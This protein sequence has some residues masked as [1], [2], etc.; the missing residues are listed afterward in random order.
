MRAQERET[1]SKSMIGMLAV[2]LAAGTA[3]AGDD[4]AMKKLSAKDWTVPGI[5]M[6]TKFIP[7]GT[8]TMGSPKDEMCRRQD[9]VQHRVAISKPFYMGVYEVTQRQFYKLMMPPDYDYEAWQ[10]KRGPIH[11]GAAFC[12][13]YRRT[14]P[15]MAGGSAVGGK[16]TD[17]NPMECVTWERAR[18]F[19]RKLTEIE[20][21]AGRLPDGY[22]YRLPTEAEWE[23]ACRAGTQG[24]YNVEGEYTSLSSIRKFAW[25]DTFSW[26]VFGTQEVG[27][28]RTPNAW[29]LYDMHGNVYEWCLDWYGP[30][31]KG[32]AVNPTG[33]AAGTEKV[34]RGGSFAGLNKGDKNAPDKKDLE[35]QV[36]PFLRSAARYSV[37]PDVSSYAIVGF[38]VV[39]GKEIAR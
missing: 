20:R 12:Y 15:L 10:Y 26:T 13:R 17:L 6:K 25:V 5:E 23:Y 38:R 22:V 33:P 8:F 30:Y 32:E 37:P 31:E 28:A 18:E 21:K 16:R 34:V 35:E 9:E 3:P 14:G 7:A 29:G 1:M 36:H 4:A 11:D 39:L 2:L 19:C 24:P 27:G